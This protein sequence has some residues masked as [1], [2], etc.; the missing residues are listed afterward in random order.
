MQEKKILS[1]MQENNQLANHIQKEEISKKDNNPYDIT[2]LKKL[3]ELKNK[4]IE[5]LQ[6]NSNIQQ[7]QLE[8]STKRNID[9]QFQIQKYLKEQDNDNTKVIIGAKDQE[10]ADLK[11][12]IK[13]ITDYNDKVV[14]M[15]KDEANRT[16]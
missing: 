7:E 2:Q 12:T 3:I 13:Q 5:R 4:E 9:Q 1:L 6:H 15:V 10:I 16:L 11:T 8:M 14:Q